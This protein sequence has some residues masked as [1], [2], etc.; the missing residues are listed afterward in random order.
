MI[1]PISWKRRG[2]L[3]VGYFVGA[4]PVV[5]YVPVP[6]VGHNFSWFH[7]PN[8]DHSADPKNSRIEITQLIGRNNI[9]IAY[10]I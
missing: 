6:V 2:V 1:V 8:A 10:I 4:A 7:F 3:V 9:I 5:G